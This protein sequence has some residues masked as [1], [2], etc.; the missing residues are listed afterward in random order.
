MFGILGG[1]RLGLTIDGE[2]HGF[3]VNG[4][5]LAGIN[6]LLLVAVM[7]VFRVLRPQAPFEQQHSGGVDITPWK[8]ARP[9]GLAIVVIVATM[10]LGLWYRF[11]LTP[12]AQ[13][14][15]DAV[16]HT[17]PAQRSGPRRPPSPRP[18]E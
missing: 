10:Y 11:G 2:F 13:V 1:G 4:L 12:G 3:E 16:A 9:A 8:Y 15:A 17:P 14:P 7:M 5:H 18:A 6:F